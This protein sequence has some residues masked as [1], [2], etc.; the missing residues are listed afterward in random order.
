MS[1]GALYP[2]YIPRAEERDIREQAALVQRDGRSRVVL[3]YGPG[4]IGKTLLVR[5]LSEAGQTQEGIIWL[6][7][8]DVDDSE[9]WLLS[10]LERHV[11]ERLDPHNR[12]FGPYLEHLSQLATYT[13]PRISHDTVVSHLGQIKRVFVDCYNRFVKD[14]GN[15][16]VIGFDTIEAVRGISF[17]LTL[18]QWIKALDSTLFIVSGRPV[19]DDG[20]GADPVQQELEDTPQGLPVTTIHLAE[21]SREAS[22]GYLSRSPITSGLGPELI[23]KLVQMTRGHPLWLAFVISYLE[24]SDIPE[25]AGAPLAVI[26]REVPFRGDM[27]GEGQI[28]YEAFKRRLV[29]PYQASDFWH[30]SVKRLAIVRQ[31]VSRDIW[32]ELMSDRPLPSGVASLDAAWEELLK[33]PW[34][35]PRANGRFVTLHDAVAEELAQRIIPVHDQG[36]QGRRELWRRAVGIYTTL[37]EGPQARLTDRLAASDEQLRQL[38]ERLHRSG[39]QDISAQEGAYIDEVTR[40]DALKR[41]IDQFKAAR[42]FYLLLSDF[43]DGCQQFLR[44]FRVAGQQN[45]V[46]FQELLALEMQR[47]L[48]GGVHR[49]AFGDV[50]GGVINDFRSWLTTE[51]PDLYLA[52]GLS[53]ADYLVKDE[54]PRQA[55]EMLHALPTSDADPRQLYQLSNLMGNAYMR[56]P[57]RVREAAKYFED[58]L[59]VARTASSPMLVAAA[60]KELGY[61]YRNEGM[62]EQADNAYKEARDAISATLSARSTDEDREEMASIQ[63]NWAY[64]KGLVGSYREGADL[65]ESAIKVRHRL[66]RPLLEGFSWSVCGEVRRYERRFHKAWE[67]Y[68]TAEQIFHGQQAWA[69]LG[70]IYQEQAICLVQATQDGISLVEEPTALAKQL[71]TW[72]LDICRNQQLRAYPSALNRAGRIFGQDDV[73]EGLS[74]LAAGI[75]EADRLRDGWFLFAN[76][77]EYAELCY[78]AWLK[79]RHESYRD[80]IERLAP[81]IRRVMDEYSFPDLRGRWDLL[82]GHLAIHDAVASEDYSGLDAALDRY[83][84]G[85]ALIAQHF[86]GS[87][88]KAA[89]PGEFETFAELLLQLPREIREQWQEELRTAWSQLEYSTPLLARLEEL[90]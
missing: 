27:T 32:K 88:G 19:P 8:I 34:I 41:D 79:R 17:L 11:A 86:V 29:T 36:K 39:E 38:E 25:E 40:L 71:I 77:I 44:L 57:G 42:L 1:E 52:I 21:F 33:I 62:W 31:A 22:E 51:N 26:E 48:P 69:G 45:D 3:L 14:T 46:L 37:T 53:M 60:H 5:H 63:T 20:D 9:Y 84:E 12:Y 49:Y 74:Y 67:A 87:S 18:T 80:Q 15:T 54:Q 64:V 50:I 43:A 61:F 65:V 23:S 68:S 7:P 59:A 24:D 81:G 73:E 16:V 13:R 6:D 72:A 75:E 82:Q 55:L 35:R 89:L 83:K 90:Y 78:R 76:R 66:N 58:A 56:V 70:L 47:F 85:F 10:N 2:D 4:G 30:E 28:I